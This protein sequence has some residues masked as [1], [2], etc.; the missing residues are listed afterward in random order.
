MIAAYPVNPGIS[1][2]GGLFLDFCMGVIRR[3]AYFKGA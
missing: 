3:R 2:L 1:P